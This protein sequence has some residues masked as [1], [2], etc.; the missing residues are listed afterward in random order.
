MAILGSYRNIYKQDY[1][2]ENQADIDTLSLTLNPAF[3]S[4]YSCLTNQV[5]LTDNIN[6][7]LSTFNTT[8]SS[9]FVPIAPL[10]IK[11]N[12]YQKSINGIVVINAVGTSNKNAL[13]TSGV[14]LNYTL[15]NSNTS[16]ST[17]NNS[18]TSSLTVNINYIVGL[19]PNVPFTITAIIF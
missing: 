15:N 14:F 19:P 16:A 10:V 4:I 8:V 18:N 13:P 3:Q 11:L 1:S 5:T 2:P 6:C 9:T 17:T 12:S 7:T